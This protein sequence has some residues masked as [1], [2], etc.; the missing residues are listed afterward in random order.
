MIIVFFGQP[1]SGKTTNAKALQR[2]FFISQKGNVPIVDG[3]D[4]RKIFNNFKN[5]CSCFVCFLLFIQQ[6]K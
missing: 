1:C 3:D 4:I 6:F 5:C 2:E